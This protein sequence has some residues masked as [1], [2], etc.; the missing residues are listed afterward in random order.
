MNLLGMLTRWTDGQLSGKTGWFA[1][2]PGHGPGPSGAA[3]R[4]A[5]DELADA[6]DELSRRPDQLSRRPGGLAGLTDESAG[7]PGH[8]AGP[9][10]ALAGRPGRLSR[11]PAESDG[12][13]V[14]P[15]DSGDGAR[16]SGAA[17]REGVD[18]L[19][20]GFNGPRERGFRAR[21]GG[22]FVPEGR[23]GVATGGASRRDAQ[24]V[25]GTRADGFCPG[26]A[27]ESS[28][29]RHGRA[30]ED[31]RF[32]RPCR[33]GIDRHDGFHGLRDGQSTVAPPVATALDPSGVGEDVPE[34]RP[35]HTPLGHQRTGGSE[36]RRG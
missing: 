10:G 32:L 20:A 28:P 26:G 23:R 2:A 8:P 22:L 19:R 1:L 30:G 29:A 11:R 9:P 3:R 14:E 15:E 16:R 4:N 31:R 6:T 13:P 35:P 7:R 27:E 5:T 36:V 34:G 21:G 25:D 33:G 18:G 24:P 17:R 12:R